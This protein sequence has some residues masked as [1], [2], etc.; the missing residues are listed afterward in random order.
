MNRRKLGKQLSVSPQ[1]LGCMGMSDSSPAAKT[2]SRW[3]TEIKKTLA[4]WKR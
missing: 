1:S 3:G 2:A 4:E